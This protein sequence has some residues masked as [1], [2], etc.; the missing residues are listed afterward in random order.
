MAER[1]I[2]ALKKQHERARSSTFREKI[3]RDI[4][5]MQEAMEGTRTYSS[6]TGKR[7]RTA[8]QVARGI[9]TLRDIIDSFPLR[10]VK[11]RN[12]SFAMR[13]NMAGN[14]SFQGPTRNPERTLGEEMAGITSAQVK[15]FF[16]ATQKAWDR[17]DVPVEHR[18]EAI[19]DKYEGKVGTRDLQTIFDYVLSNQRNADVAKAKDIVANPDKYTDGEK[20]WA[21][22]VLA[23]NDAEV[24]YMP[25]VTAAAVSDVSPVAPM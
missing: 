13:L 17:K 10:G 9:E 7:I 18:L 12:R 6:E 19:I 15:V 22:D 5:R 4:T 16:R 20:E 23:D 2:N 24:R 3:Q 1:R 11:K 21:Y 8:S 25:T 14:K